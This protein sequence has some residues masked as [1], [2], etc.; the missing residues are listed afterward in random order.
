MLKLLVDEHVPT[1]LLRGLLRREP[2]LDIVR[3]QDVGLSSVPD[4]DVLEWAAR[5]GR[6]L[7]TLDVNSAVGAAY[8]RLAQGRNMP[9]VFAVT[10]GISLG[11]AIESLLML[12]MASLPGE[13]DGQVVYLPL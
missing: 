8:E 13:W 2:V 6:V 7:I 9:G 11:R 3:V 5:E 4:P 12:S 10:S 1:Q